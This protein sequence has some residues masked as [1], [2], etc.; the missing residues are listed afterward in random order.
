MLSLYFEQL[1]PVLVFCLLT[2]SF[3]HTA[4]IGRDLWRE[5]S[6]T[7]KSERFSTQV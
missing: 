6:V 2:R 3:L 4:L 5:E 1:P 7:D